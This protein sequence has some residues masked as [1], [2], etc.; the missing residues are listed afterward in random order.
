MTHT[1]TRCILWALNKPK[2]RGQSSA[3]DLAGR[4]YNTGSPR[5]YS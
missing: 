4:A 1:V 3:P 2:I 5:I